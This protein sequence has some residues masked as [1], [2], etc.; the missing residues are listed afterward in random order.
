MASF[1]YTLASGILFY[2][3]KK[4]LIPASITLRMLKVDQFIIIVQPRLDIKQ[5]KLKTSKQNII[6]LLEDN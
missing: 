5:I 3:R 6:N 1:H 4:Y 2:I